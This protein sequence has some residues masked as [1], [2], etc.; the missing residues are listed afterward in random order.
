MPPRPSL[1]KIRAALARDSEGFGRLVESRT[2]RRRFGTL[3]EDAMLTRLPRGFDPGHPA[4]R[5]L[6]YQSFTCSRDLSS[7]EIRSPGLPRLLVDDFVRMLPFVRW[8]NSALGFSPATSRLPRFL[9]DIPSSR[10]RRLHGG[11]E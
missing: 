2:F 3:D 11:Q 4:E 8:L 5:W 6:R 7:R 10:T 1:M 9:D